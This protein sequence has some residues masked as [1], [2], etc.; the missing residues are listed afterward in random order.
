MLKIL[1]LRFHYRL[2]DRLICQRAQTDVAFRWFLGLACHEQLPDP[3]TA[4]Y[5]RR[6]LGVERLQQVFDDLVSL[7]REL[8]LVKDRL[9]LKDA[10]H[11]FADVANVTPLTLAAQVREHLLHAAEP[12]FPGWV[13]RQGD[14][15]QTLRQATAELPD[16]DRLALRVAYLRNAASELRE[17]LPTLPTLT[18]VEPTRQRLD[19][20]LQIVAKLLADHADP[21]AGD[22]LASVSDPEARVGK[23]GEFFVGYLLDLAIDADSEI[24]TAIHVLPGNGAE[25]ADTVTRIQQ[26]ESAH[27]NDVAAV[28]LDGIGYNGPLLRELT[29]PAGLNLEVTV[30]PPATPQR[31][32]FGPERFAL[33]VLPE[34]KGEVTCPQGERTRQRERVDKDTGWKYIFK[35]GQCGGCPQRGE[36]LQNPASQNGRTV[37]KNDYEAEYAQVQSRSATAA[38]QQTRREHPKIERKLGEVVRQHGL[39]RV[40]YRGQDKVRRQAL[41]T[42]WVVNVK[43]LVRLVGRKG[44]AAARTA[45]VRAE[46]VSG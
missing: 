5:F 14:D 12:L 16:D 4:S 9:R 19:R 7:A 25:A 36:C 43:R 40:S 24:I 15:L 6:R 20:A 10:T 21:K 45:G 37:I 23:H 34:Q 35:P 22:R 39:R 31:K 32:T 13:R 28:S 17:L 8:G 33:T 30:P 29:D 1:F 3:S 42:G 2:S 38:Y 41:L 11:L 44:P 26:E 18:G 46:G 27:G